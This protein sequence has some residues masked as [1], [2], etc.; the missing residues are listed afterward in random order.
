V[1]KHDIVVIGASAGG[2]DPLRAVLA[3]LDSRFPA[4]LFLVSHLA[5][6]R[7]RLDDVLAGAT[8]LSVMFAE[9]REAIR[10]GTL[11]IAPPDRHLILERGRIML[12]RG[13]RENLWRPSIDVLFRS[14]AVAFGT[15]VI[16]IVLSGSL[17][18]GA[19]GLKAVAQCGGVC[20]VQAPDDA[21]YPEM[22]Q[23]A[24]RAVPE[25]RVMTAHEIAAALP[26]MVTATAA[27]T[28]PI[29]EQIRLE[30]R[31]AAG[32][33][34]AMREIEARGQP[35]SFNCPECGGPLNREPGALLRFR[36]RLGHSFAAASLG[37]ASGRAVESSLWAAIRLLEQRA[38][39]DRAR[40]AE[41]RDRGRAASAAAYQ[42]RS[43][44]VTG[45][46]HVLREM[47]A[48]LP[49]DG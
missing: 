21:A 38:N 46:A 43:T 45:H 27:P 40:G 24:L 18:D 4:A 47:L 7:S 35:T 3:P 26:A 48:K 5:P 25:A 14:A 1:D 29:P 17:D 34:E 6:G 15:R 28:A 31:I 22:P 44:E 32:D 11:L 12:R 8:S 10:P 16:G 42:Q 33:E 9:D 37:E 2:F 13:P 30:A 19:T 36:C 49:S 41:E 39:L 23:S 20:I